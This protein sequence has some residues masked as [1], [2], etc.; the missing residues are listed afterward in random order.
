MALLPALV[1]L[2]PMPDG[3][4]FSAPLVND[5]D[6]PG[7]VLPLVKGRINYWFRHVW[8]YWWPL[9]GGVLLAVELSGLQI[10]H[11][12]AAGVPIT[13]FSIAGGWLFLLRR[14][15]KKAKH[16]GDSFDISSLIPV[17]IVIAVYVPVSGL[18]PAVGRVSKYLPIAIGII[19]SMSYLQIRNPLS[20]KT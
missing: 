6:S 17:V 7:A 15:E 9:Y 2:L 10:E 3:A 14:V 5:C 13:F 1:G 20:R 4:L 12:V 8:E 11:F 18:L 19:V 16:T